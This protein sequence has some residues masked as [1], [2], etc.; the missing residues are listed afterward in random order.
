MHIEETC[1]HVRFL[2]NWSL[3]S[4]GC[5]M[6]ASELPMAHVCVMLQASIARRVF[7]VFT[8]ENEIS[9]TVLDGMGVLRPF[10]W[11]GGFDFSY[12]LAFDMQFNSTCKVHA[13]ICPDGQTSGKSQFKKLP[14]GRFSISMPEQEKES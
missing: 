1:K 12:K 5:S 6:L 14:M 13:S 10:P 3:E 8:I 7:W 9:W 4:D 11:V 2:I